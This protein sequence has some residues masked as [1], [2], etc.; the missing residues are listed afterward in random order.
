MK[1]DVRQAIFI[2][3]KY[4][5]QR[6]VCNKEGENSSPVDQFSFVSLDG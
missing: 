2:K 4:I 5:Q 6:M 1:Q 3:N